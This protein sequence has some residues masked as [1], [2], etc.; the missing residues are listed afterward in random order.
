MTQELGEVLQRW[1]EWLRLEKRYSDHTLDAYSRDFADYR[2]MQAKQGLPLLPP[3]RQGFRSWLADMQARG[4]SKSSVA[5]RVSS[6]RNFYNFGTRH[7]FFT[8]DDISWMKAPKLARTL[9]STLT[10]DDAQL[11]LDCLQTQNRPDWEKKRDLAILM[12]MYGAGLRL[13]E[14]LSLKASDLPL[15]PWLEITGKGQKTRSVPIL[16]ILQEAVSAARAS[17][18]FQPQGDQ[19]LFCSSRGGPYGPRAVQRMVE[20]LRLAAGLPARTTPHSLRH[21]FATHLL[22]GGGDLRSIQQLL[23]H[24]SLSTTQRY[25]HLDQA[26]LRAIY[27]ETHPRAT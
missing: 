13:S 16:A 23:G 3:D 6:V 7:H 5:R 15:G 24:A 19:P 25:T 17:C 1:E 27:Q 14:A 21:A 8:L 18:P 20:K 4:L 11:M 10:Q 26:R 9:P 22:E 2:A 12:L